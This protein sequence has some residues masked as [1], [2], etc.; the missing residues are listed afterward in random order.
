MTPITGPAAEFYGVS[1]VAIGMFAMSFMIAF[2]PLSLPASWLIDTRGF[3]VAVG[4][5]S[6]VMGACGVLRGLAGDSYAL[7]MAA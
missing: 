7:A 1:D 6:I 5:G 2:I 4:L 3:R